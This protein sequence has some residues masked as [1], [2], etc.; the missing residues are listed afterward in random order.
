MLTVLLIAGT[1]LTSGGV[2]A[3]AEPPAGGQASASVKPRRTAEFLDSMGIAAHLSDRDYPTAPEI[4][5]KVRYLGVRHVRSNNMTN[6]EGVDPGIRKAILSTKALGG[7]GVKLTLV[8]ARPL[9]SK[10]TE[11]DLRGAVSKTIDYA[12]HNGLLQHIDALEIFTEYDNR[13]PK[14]KN[15]PDALKTAMIA[16]YEMR[17]RLAPGTKLLGPSLLGYNMP[18]TAPLMRTDA[19]GQPMNKYFD[20]GNIHSYYVGKRPESKFKD[21]TPYQTPSQ[22]NVKPPSMERAV[23]MDQR[24][25]LYAYNISRDK[26]IMITETGY[27][28]DPNGLF[29]G[30]IDEA[31]AG[32]YVPRAYLDAFRIGI[33]R[34][35]MYELFDEPSAMPQYQQF[36]GFFR[37]GGQARPHAVATHNLTT[38]LSGGTNSFTPTALSYGCP[39][40]SRLGLETVLLQ[41]KPGEYWLAIWRTASVFNAGTHVPI[42]QGNVSTKLTFTSPKRV[43]FHK[44][45]SLTPDRSVTSNPTTSITVPIGPK[46]SLI[47]ITG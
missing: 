35:Y 42:P 18:K 12:D 41:K 16:M 40:C 27:N 44:D 46:V 15:W 19:N 1:G 39:D 30:R 34:T 26:P 9:K 25:K 29:S 21:A 17:G 43:T 45:L 22:F 13:Y 28:T 11:A 3:A 33:Q 7:H 31:G 20:S 14:V 4:V 5:E 2:V 8:I 47:K 24:L 6:L 37:H 38:L 10:P 23:S 32:V 36:F